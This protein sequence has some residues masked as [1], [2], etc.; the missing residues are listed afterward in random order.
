MKRVL[1][2]LLPLVQLIPLAVYA[3]DDDS[4][5]SEGASWVIQ[6]MYGA[7]GI[8]IATLATI[9]VGL[10]CLAHILEWKRLLQTIVGMCI[11]F[12]AGPLVTA[13]TSRVHHS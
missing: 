9:G 12:G 2:W 11:I 7:T 6:T 8:T 5:I 3:A 13:I 10:L 4:P 1:T